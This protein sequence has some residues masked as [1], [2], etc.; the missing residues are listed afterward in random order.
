MSGTKCFFVI[1]FIEFQLVHF[2]CYNTECKTM[3]GMIA[4]TAVFIC[5]QDAMLLSNFAAKL[6]DTISIFIEFH[7]LQASGFLNGVSV[8]PLEHEKARRT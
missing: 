1:C 7:Y 3:Q 8:N 4:V 5:R 2:V 6:L